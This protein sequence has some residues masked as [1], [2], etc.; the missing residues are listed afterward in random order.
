MLP[1]R[2]KSARFK[3]L[4]P[5][6]EGLL[7]QGYSYEEVTQVLSFEHD[8]KLSRQHFANYLSRYR[9][10]A[11]ETTKQGEQVEKIIINPSSPISPPPPVAKE[12]NTEQDSLKKAR[13]LL[14]QERQKLDLTDLLGA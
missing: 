10:K 11:K 1:P 7:E 13:E 12:Q 2:K 8:L 4:L 5:K 14:A 6:I 9:P 3:Q